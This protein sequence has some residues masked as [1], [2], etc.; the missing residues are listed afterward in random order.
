MA[1]NFEMSFISS[2]QPNAASQGFPTTFMRDLIY[3][4]EHPPREALLARF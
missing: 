4:V 2:H 1:Q 3:L